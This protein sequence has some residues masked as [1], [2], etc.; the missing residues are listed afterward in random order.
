MPDGCFMPFTFSIKA[1]SKPV[2]LNIKFASIYKLLV[3]FIQALRFRYKKWHIV[4]P[5]FKCLPLATSWVCLLPVGMVRM[6]GVIWSKVS[7][8]SAKN[9]WHVACYD[10]HKIRLQKHQNLID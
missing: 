2:G 8:C 1:W 10:S 3:Y 7:C 9:L 4:A 6:V 5:F